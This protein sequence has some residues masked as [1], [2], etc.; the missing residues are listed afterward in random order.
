[1]L[2]VWALWKRV[3]SN[4]MFVLLGVSV[5]IA[6]WLTRDLPEKPALP[7]LNWAAQDSESYRVLMRFS[8]ESQYAS[9]DLVAN[10]AI[11]APML[12]TQPNEWLGFVAE[13]RAGIEQAWA[14][15][16]LGRAWIDQLGATFPEGVFRTAHNDPFLSFHATL[17]V[18]ERRLSY[19]LLLALDGKGEEAAK[20]INGS[21]RAVQ[22]MQ[23]GGATLVTQMIAQVLLRRS[24]FGVSSLLDAALLNDTAKQKLRSELG[25][26]LPLDSN[27]Q[28]SVD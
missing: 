2:L 26:M 25:A 22:A 8:R 6:L 13:H 21:L 11:K 19:A 15:D 14:A 1:M 18:F 16:S 24:V 5:C 27:F 7:E 17:Q 10:I 23:K 4:L 12:P 9:P 3:S 20:L 28:R